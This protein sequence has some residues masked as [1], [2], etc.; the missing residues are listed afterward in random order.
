M[1][2]TPDTETQGLD[3]L[4]RNNSLCG[5]SDVS[6]HDEDLRQ[7]LSRARRG[8]ARVV[9]RT[10]VQ[11]AAELDNADVRELREW[12]NQARVVSPTHDEIQLW[13]P[14]DRPIP[15]AVATLLLEMVR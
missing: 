8:S 5:K 9:T 10:S 6:P 3:A 14:T 4:R 15:A 11:V 2:G 12:L 13:A 1:V 7:L